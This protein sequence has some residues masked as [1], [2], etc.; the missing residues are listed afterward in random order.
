[1]P[2]P[3]V[4]GGPPGLGQDPVIGSSGD[5][6][7]GVLGISSQGDGVQGRSHDANHSGV[8]GVNDGGGVGTFGRGTPAGRFDG[9]LVVNGNAT[10]N[11]NLAMGSGGDIMFAD[12]A[13]EFE[14]AGDSGEPDPGN[15]MVLDADGGIRACCKPYDTRA[16]GVVAGAGSFRSAI[17]L[18]R[19]ES[20]SNR[21]AIALIGKVCCKVDAT[22]APVEVGDLLTTSPTNGHAMKAID[23]MTAFGTVIGKAIEPL[24]EGRGLIRILV[25]LQ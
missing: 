4:T 25:T 21:A 2:L 7:P 19:L 11:G 6:R 9:E 23:P 3:P 18:D 12:C 20:A 1:M 8:A 15:V 17:V 16:V 24:R 14:V 5:S 10:I 22:F 13:E